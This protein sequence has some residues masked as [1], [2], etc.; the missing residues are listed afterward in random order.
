MGRRRTD[1]PL[2]Y[3]TCPQER[4]LAVLEPA[5]QD[6]GGSKRRGF[7]TCLD[8]GVQGRS[9]AAVG[10]SRGAS[11]SQEA[12]RGPRCP[13]ASRSRAECRSLRCSGGALRGESWPL[14]R[15]GLSRGAGGA[16]GGS[17]WAPW[18]SLRLAEPCSRGS[19]GAPSRLLTLLLCLGAPTR[20]RWNKPRGTTRHTSKRCILRSSLMCRL[21]YFS[22]TFGQSW[23]SFEPIGRFPV[24]AASGVSKRRS[25]CVKPRPCFRYERDNPYPVLYYSHDGFKAYNIANF[26]EPVRFSL[27][28]DN[29]ALLQQDSCRCSYSTVQ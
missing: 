12:H 5:R 14:L 20:R 26:R 23:Q 18:P 1:P 22:A 19:R 29:I 13:C 28:L 2:V 11:P 7:G 27:S 10:G 8:F 9:H 16:R 6:H 24:S 25:P 17:R 21:I 3:S 15:P 4:F